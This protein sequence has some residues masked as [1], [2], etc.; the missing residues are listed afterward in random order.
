MLILE[1]IKLVNAYTV[2]AFPKNLGIVFKTNH[3]SHKCGNLKKYYM[4]T[5]YTTED[6]W[7]ASKRIPVHSI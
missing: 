2:R 1:D 7:C 3:I 6:A 4:Y 5:R